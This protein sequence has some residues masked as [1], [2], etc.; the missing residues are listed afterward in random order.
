[1][2]RHPTVQRTR[3]V[4]IVVAGACLAAGCTSKAQ[5]HFIGIEHLTESELEEIRSRCEKAA[6]RATQREE[7]A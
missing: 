4:A 7:A 2:R 6:R 3:V 1:M 5:N